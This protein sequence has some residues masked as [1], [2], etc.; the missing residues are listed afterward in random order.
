MRAFSKDILRTIGGSKKRYLSIVAIC[1]LGA[2]M[3]T[4]LSI[5]CLDYSPGSILQFRIVNR[6]IRACQIPVFFDQ[7]LRGFRS[8]V[9]LT[10]TSAYCGNFMI[11]IE[12]TIFICLL[13][14]SLQIK[15]LFNANAACQKFSPIFIK[16]THPTIKILLR[17]AL[18]KESRKLRPLYRL[19]IVLNHKSVEGFLQSFHIYL[20]MQW[21]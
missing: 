21:I 20:L 5:A 11:D 16:H 10:R 19:H 1:A 13:I 15:E 14:I 2:T 3:L 7:F 8:I 18:I 4:G 17:N 9:S 12:Y 6:I